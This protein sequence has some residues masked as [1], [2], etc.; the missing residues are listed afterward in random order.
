MQKD[1]M[2]KLSVFLIIVLLLACSA[3]H[4]I[5]LKADGSIYSGGKAISDEELKNNYA[6][7]E[8]ILRVNHDVP[9]EK[10]TELMGKLKEGGVKKVTI[11]ANISLEE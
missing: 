8:V 5:H 3:T 1:N 11:N 2:K 7:S 9:Y 4:E 6:F 10:V